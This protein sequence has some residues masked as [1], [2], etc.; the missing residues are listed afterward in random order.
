MKVSFMIR[1]V[2]RVAGDTLVCRVLGQTAN[3]ATESCHFLFLEEVLTTRQEPCQR[4]SEASRR[5]A[6]T[7]CRGEIGCKKRKWQ[8]PRPTAPNCGFRGVL[9]TL[10]LLW[11]TPVTRRSYGWARNQSFICG[12]GLS[13]SRRS[14]FEFGT[15]RAGLKTELRVHPED[16]LRTDTFS[17]GPAGQAHSF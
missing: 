15:S 8:R 6:L 13:C 4:P 14:N 3:A 9:T 7:G 2:K 16:F 10:S 1:K 12:I 11:R 5:E 17:G